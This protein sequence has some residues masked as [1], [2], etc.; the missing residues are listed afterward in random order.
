MAQPFRIL[1]VSA[2]AEPFVKVGGLGDVAGAL[3]KALLALP[4]N[5]LEGYSL[6]VRLVLPFHSFISREVASPEPVAAVQVPRRDGFVEARIFISTL[7]GFPVYLIEGD[8]ISS[9]PSVYSLDSFQDAEKFI[10][11]SLAV[12]EMLK[13]LDWKPHVLHAHDWHT[14]IAVYELNRRRSQDDFYQGIKSLFTIHNLPYMG[15]GAEKVLP[16]Y[17]I[18][19]S[20]DIRM[21]WWGKSL[22]LPMALSS[23]DFINTV[24]P[25]YSR[26]MLTSE[27]GCGLE[28][29]L[30]SRSSTLFG[31]LNGLDT[32]LWNPET[33]PHIFR[34]FSAENLHERIYNK[35]ALLES[36]GLSSEGEAPLLGLIGRF[37]RQK[38]IDLA[39]EALQMLGDV[40]WQAVI[41]G[42]GDPALEESV[43]GLEREF[44]ERVR[45]VIRFDAKLSHQIYAGADMLLMP[46]RYEPCGLAQMIAMRYGCIPVARA[47]GGLKDTISD[48]TDPSLSTGFLF[49]EAT[50]EALAEAIRRAMA[51]YTDPK[52]WE[53]RQRYAMQ[54][55][56]SWNRSAL[57]YYRLYRLLWL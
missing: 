12:L 32:E 30:R 6:D 11:F 41:L 19:P 38:G 14:G 34:K 50:P 26:E 1:M 8:P 57:E 40:P 9:A 20:D 7:P 23:A 37:D 3:P 42:S 22:P 29:F 33:D 54:Q 16:D 17:H 18:P 49:G 45:A 10:F 4:E 46:S 48:L 43:R 35:P 47:T 52:G 27:F 31:I 13:A 56:F 44:P 55:D 24:S 51:A 25:G 53:L 39:V 5:A 21:P 36:L 2:E 28:D 15:A